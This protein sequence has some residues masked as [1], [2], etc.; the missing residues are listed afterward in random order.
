MG[1]AWRLPGARGCRPQ[2]PAPLPRVAEHAGVRPPLDRPQGRRGRAAT[3]ATSTAPASSPRTR[4][5]RCG[6]RRARPGSRGSRPPRRPRR[7]STLLE[8]VRP[9]A[10]DGRPEEAA[11]A[12]ATNG[13]GDDPIAAALARRD[14]ALLEVLYGA[15]LRAA[16]CCGLRLSDCE[17]E[18]GLV[19]VLGKGSKVRRVPLGIPACDALRD[20]LR[21]GRP[22][23]ATPDSPPDAVF[24][25]RRGG[26][27]GTR[28]AHR[29]VDAPSAHRRTASA[30]ARAPPRLRDAPARR[31]RRP[32]RRAG[33]PRARRPRDDPDLHA[34]HARST[35]RGLR[36][37][38]SSCLTTSTLLRCCAQRPRS[39]G[40]GTSTRPTRL[41]TRAS[42]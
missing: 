19:T 4:A 5:G 11:L 12:P 17:L 8:R 10:L 15:G 22:V 23:L 33:A 34:P 32:A 25:A 3:S 20:W 2:G 1:R 16:E 24:L 27:M 30:P 38:A 7:S 35:A 41:P 36:R 29:V 40:S 6:R 31:W 21:L 39:R 9:P 28:E 26:A 18:R 42:G 37:H 14:L 13:D